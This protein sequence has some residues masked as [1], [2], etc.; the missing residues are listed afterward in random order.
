MDLFKVFFQSGPVLGKGEVGEMVDSSPCALFGFEVCFELLPIEWL[1]FGN[2][3]LP[4]L[5]LICCLRCQCINQITFI[6]IINTKSYPLKE[7]LHL[8]WLKFCVNRHVFFNGFSFENT[9]FLFV[10]WITLLKFNSDEHLIIPV[11]FRKKSVVHE[12]RSV[13]FWQLVANPCTLFDS[14]SSSHDKP[15]PFITI[16]SLCLL[17]PQRIH[18]INKRNNGNSRLTINHQIIGPT[19][20][21]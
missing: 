18:H 20:H 5:F 4:F 16:L 7:F 12:E 10:E 15:L 8:L 21:H 6:T 14:L 19:T 9:Q 3:F 11:W 13:A 1:V 2:I 17:G